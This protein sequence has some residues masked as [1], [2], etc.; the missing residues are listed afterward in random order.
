MAT[1]LAI[2]RRPLKSVAAADDL[3]AHVR[4]R[5]HETPTMRYPRLRSR[6]QV[7][8][9]SRVR[10]P[11]RPSHAP[12]AI[13]LRQRKMRFTI[14]I[15]DADMIRTSETQNQWIESMGLVVSRLSDLQDGQI[16][17]N[18]SDACPADMASLVGSVIFFDQNLIEIPSPR[19][20][21]RKS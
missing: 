6:V 21:F 20:I 11:D 4:R 16:R 1:G 19:H 7:T 17:A 3:A 5:P 8:R 9:E 10:E 12:N 2:K 14:A 18:R 13:I 15:C